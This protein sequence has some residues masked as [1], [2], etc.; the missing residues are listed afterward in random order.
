MKITAIEE[1]KKNKNRKSVFLDGAFAFG[2]DAFSLY[3]LKL[4]EGDE[5]DA[6]QLAEIK[7]TVLL[8]EA[9]AKAI[10][11][12]SFRSY[13]AKDMQ[14]KLLDYTK[15]PETTDK[16]MIFLEE[17][18]L[19]NDKDYARRYASDCLK[20]KKLGKRSIR[21]KLL[22]K[23]ISA[24][25]ADEILEE[26]VDKETEEENLEY[27]L[28]KKIKGNFDFKNLQKAKRYAAYRGYG[29]DEIDS[30]IRK[31]QPESEANDVC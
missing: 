3:A 20:L 16:T 9:K 19:V 26:F 8:E 25:L 28:T 11:L 18:G 13:T 6:S 22:E 7:R 23:G 27:L 30:V 2:I 24:T 15:D 31:L 17:Y 29:F 4:K 10:K 12:L 1:Q 21:M 5:I 14:K